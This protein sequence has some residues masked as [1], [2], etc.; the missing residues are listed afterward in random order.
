MKVLFTFGGIPHYL[1][2]LLNRLIDEDVNVTVVVPRKGNATIG[3]GVKMVDGGTYRRVETLERKMWYGKPGFP[4][5]SDFIY[6]ENPDIVVM[7][8]PYYLQYAFQPSV[9]KAV[10]ARSTRLVLREIPFQIPPFGGI[11]SYF[12]RHPM[13]DENMR[14]LSHGA[15]FLLKQ[16]FTAVVRRYLYH[17]A[18]G[19]LC[20]AST[21]LSILPT[22]GISSDKLY[23]TYNTTDTTSLQR[24]KETVQS[25]APLLPPCPRRVLHIGRLV[26][27]KR[28]D[29]LIEA[30]A[31]ISGKYPDAELLIVGDGPEMTA[32]Q[33]QAGR[34][35]TAKDRIRFAGAVYEARQ[36]GAYMNESAVYVLAGMGGLSLN[37]AMTYGLPVVCSECD[38][39]EKDLVTD[40]L[41][42][43]YFRPGDADSLAERLDTLLSSPE[44]MKEMGRA[45][46]EIIRHKINMDTVSRRYIEAFQAM[47]R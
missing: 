20:Y 33:Q 26:K 45:S 44:K 34:L 37:D 15:G 39:T 3:Q 30:F 32:L 25:S 24:Q 17:Q 42:G 1:D 13:V 14:I 29:L 2:A 46:E 38:G 18:K 12:R 19:I 40:G 43:F 5:L 7:G 35:A 11:K 16:G 47:L 23:V 21:G 31:K 8:W 28:V 36:L 10:K 9:R 41:N 22:Y 6:D 27:W 4:Y